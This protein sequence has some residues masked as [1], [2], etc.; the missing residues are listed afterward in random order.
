MP[1]FIER[2]S[3]ALSTATRDTVPSNTA[4]SC[5][6]SSTADGSVYKGFPHNDPQCNAETLYQECLDSFTKHSDVISDRATD[7]MKEIGTLQG[8]AEHTGHYK[9][10]GEYSAVMEATAKAAIQLLATYTAL[11][12]TLLKGASHHCSH[13]VLPFGLA[14]NDHSQ[15]DFEQQAY[16]IAC[17]TTCSECE[18]LQDGGEGLVNIVV[19]LRKH[20]ERCV[21][22]SVERIQAIV[23]CAKTS[24]TRQTQADLAARIRHAFRKQ[25]DV[26]LE[27]IIPQSPEPQALGDPS[28]PS[29]SPGSNPDTADSVGEIKRCLEAW[30]SHTGPG[31]ETNYK[32]W[33]GGLREEEGSFWEWCMGLAEMGV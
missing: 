3:T 11:Y 16:R 9:D 30:S 6:Q 18:D 29:E 15:A 2:L 12:E 28:I 24:L 17:G 25:Y 14:S 5:N 32:R 22:E 4:S 26:A 8:V 10:F 27:R 19:D 33:V 1:A 20:A 7:F 31:L 21:S 13:Q 23:D